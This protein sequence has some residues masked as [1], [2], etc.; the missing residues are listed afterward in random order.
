MS[1]MRQE[2]DGKTRSSSTIKHYQHTCCTKQQS[3]CIDKKKPGVAFF[4]S[5]HLITGFSSPIYR[6]VN[7][8]SG[9]R[10]TALSLPQ[11]VRFATAQAARQPE[12]V[13][14]KTSSSFVPYQWQ[15]PLK[16][17]ETML[18]EDEQAIMETARDY[19]QDN[20]QPRVI[21]AYRNESRSSALQR[22]D[23]ER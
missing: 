18:T 2:K 11:Q 13:L 14:Q 17:E 23:A 8:L 7:M 15:D 19:C 4:F 10:R 20:L 3:A 9:F 5:A 21:E 22:W 16:V 1:T 12:T 6:G